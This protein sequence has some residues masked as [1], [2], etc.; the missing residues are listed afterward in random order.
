M[1]SPLEVGVAQTARPDLKLARIPA[2]TQPFGQ[3]ELSPTG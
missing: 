1:N 3:L 2:S